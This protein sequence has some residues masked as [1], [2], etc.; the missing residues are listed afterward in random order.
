MFSVLNGDFRTRTEVGYRG[1]GIPRIYQRVKSNEI[2]N[3]VLIANN[4]YVNCT[5]NKRKELKNK[6]HGT[7]FSWEFV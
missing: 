5:T 3:L 2:N 7:L 6:F 1:K 4:G